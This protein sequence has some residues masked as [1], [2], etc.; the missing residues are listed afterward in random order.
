MPARPSLSP[1]FH[2]VWSATLRL[3]LSRDRPG[4]TRAL[5][6]FNPQHFPLPAFK[7]ILASLTVTNECL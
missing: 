6:A 3:S 5:Q 4:S 2:Q 7:Q 1:G